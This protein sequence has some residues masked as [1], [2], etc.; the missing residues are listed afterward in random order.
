MSPLALN[1]CHKPMNIC[2]RTHTHTR[3][4]TSHAKPFSR[5]TRP[6]ELRERAFARAFENIPF[7]CS[8]NG[9]FGS[10]KI[11][12]FLPLV[13]RISC[14]SEISFSTKF[15]VFGAK[16][17]VKSTV[18]KRQ[19]T[20]LASVK[21]DLFGKGHRER[22]HTDPLCTVVVLSTR[23]R[24]LTDFL[25]RSWYHQITT[26]V[27]LRIREDPAIRLNELTCS[28]RKTRSISRKVKSRV[29][30]VRQTRFLFQNNV[31]LN[32]IRQR[33]ANAYKLNA[34]Q[35][36]RFVESNADCEIPRESGRILED[37]HCV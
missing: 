16:R 5:N 34:A 28:T 31:H 11:P 14:C 29:L 33:C 2:T 26:T 23:K 22:A 36:T 37:K 8:R 25:S 13:W 10:V 24:Y 1:R 32:G 3:V 18:L 27:P 6:K 35:W 12:S 9:I 17:L 30:L 15:L 7:N 20:H 4:Y 19:V 21:R